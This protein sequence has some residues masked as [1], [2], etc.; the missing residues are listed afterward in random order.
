MAGTSSVASFLAACRIVKEENQA[1]NRQ[2]H[3]MAREVRSI[4]LSSLVVGKGQIRLRQVDASVDELAE[5]IRKIGLLEPILVAPAKEGGK[6]EILAGQRRFLAASR[7]GLSEIEAVISEQ[8]DETRAKVISLTENMVRRDI[9]LADKID[10]CTALY[11]RYGSVRTVAEETGLPER[12]VSKYV[13]YDQLNPELKQLFD[14]GRLKLEDALAVQRAASV[15]GE[16]DPETAAK[17]AAEIPSMI[18]AQR[19][20]LVKDLV[21]EPDRSVDDVIEDQKSNRRLVQMNIRLFV[22]VKER[23][24]RFADIE[25]TTQEDAARQLI[26]EG[27]AAKGFGE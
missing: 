4:P 20:R 1:N 14:E 26:E 13:K 25:G 17:L 22:S 18:G 24:D 8:V 7:L 12:E 5:S 11:K 3:P 21:A 6:Y 15:R 19:D 16:F 10:A 27:L 23:L 9:V 2:V